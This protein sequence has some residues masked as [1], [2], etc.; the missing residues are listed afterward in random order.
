MA[1]FKL[2]KNYDHYAIVNDDADFIAGRVYPLHGQQGPYRVRADVG[3]M[4]RETTE[5][6]VV[7][8][9]NDAIPAFLT[10]Y[11]RYPVRWERLDTGEYGKDTLNALLRVVHGEGG[12]VAYRDNYPLL[13]DGKPAR[14][15][16]CA[17]AQRAADVHEL[18]LFANA[19]AIDDGLSW[20]PDPEIDWR[21]VP[22]RVEARA[23]WQRNASN[24]LP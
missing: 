12:W 8:S 1:T 3:P 5:A 10:Y 16:T 21:S 7:N 13:R 22:H 9:L 4:E 19:M 17:E 6:G 20:F 15:A 23:N 24:F 11:E 2:L 18:D 14:F